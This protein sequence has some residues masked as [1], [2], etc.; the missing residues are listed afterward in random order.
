MDYNVKFVH[1][2]GKI[3]HISLMGIIDICYKTYC[4]ETQNVAP[5]LPGFQG[6]KIFFDIWLFTHI[7]PSFI[8]IIIMM[9]QMPSDLHGVGI[10]LK[11]TQ[12]IIV[13]NAVKMHIMLEFST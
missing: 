5:T 6:I 12:L 4:L 3:Q 8:I 10:K 7:N 2:L 11:T 9:A 13:Y 1:T